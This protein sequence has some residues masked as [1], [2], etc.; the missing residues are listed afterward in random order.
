MTTRTTATRNVVVTVTDVEEAVIDD[1]VA[2]YDANDDG[3][4]V[5]DEV[6]AAVKAY[7]NDEITADE[8][9]AVVRQYFADARAS[10]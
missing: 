2:L 3:M 7:F 4:I 6:L 8:V 1:P 10:S 9:L 5:A